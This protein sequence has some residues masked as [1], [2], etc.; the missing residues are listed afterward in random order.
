L[1]STCVGLGRGVRTELLQESNNVNLLNHQFLCAKCLTGGRAWTCSL[2]LM[3]TRA[4]ETESV[5]TTRCFKCDA[6]ASFRSSASQ[7]RGGFAVD[8]CIAAVQVHSRGLSTHVI[9]HLWDTI[10]DISFPV[11]RAPSHVVWKIVV[12]GRAVTIIV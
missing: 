8:H 6:Y 10:R 1:P 7:L 9:I 3:G 12:K 5:I 4:P 11:T 2:H